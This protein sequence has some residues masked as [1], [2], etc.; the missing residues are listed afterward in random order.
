[1]YYVGGERISGDILSEQKENIYSEIKFRNLKN[2]VEL[3]DKLREYLYNGNVDIIGNVLHKGWLYKKELASRVS[4]QGVDN[5]YEKAMKC[6][7]T[8]GKLLGA[9]GTGFLL[10]HS[11]DH[12]RLKKQMGC[13][14]LPL[15]ID[16]E[17]AKVIFYE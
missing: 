10:F 13:K 15:A 12:E 14:V 8:G 6:G 1:M 7:A 11:N 2:M 4:N 17:G 3:A 9:G 5:L 16:K